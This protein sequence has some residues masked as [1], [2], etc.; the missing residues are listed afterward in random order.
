R[1][2]HRERLRSFG[3]QLTEDGPSYVAS[4]E[5]AS[6]GVQ[7]VYG[8]T[9]Q[10]SAPGQAIAVVVVSD[11][12][13]WSSSAA[14]RERLGSLSP[15]GLVTTV[16]LAEGMKGPEPTWGEITADELVLARM[17]LGQAGYW[18]PADAERAWLHEGTQTTG[19]DTLADALGA[20]VTGTGRLLGAPCGAGN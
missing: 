18:P 14:W 6:S 8:S 7:L 19:Y 13:E 5:G 12:P 3:W 11:E 4:R 2:A 9:Y 10:V 1:E 20:W 16:P 15:R 17:W